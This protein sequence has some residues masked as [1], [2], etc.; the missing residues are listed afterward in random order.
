MVNPPSSNLMPD[1]TARLKQQVAELQESDFGLQQTASIAHWIGYGLLIFTLF[2]W[3]YLLIPLKVM[4]PRWEF[5]TMGGLVEQ[6]VVPLLGFGLVFFGADLSRK[7]WEFAL[8]KGLSWLCLLLGLLY[9][10]LLPLGVVN[11]VRLDGINQR[12]LV[13]NQDQRLEVIS[14]VKGQVEAIT[15]EADLQRVIEQLKK[16]GLSIQPKPG[17]SVTAIKADLTEFMNSAQAKL[18]TEV[19]AATKQGRFSLFK[20][21]LRW[22]LGAL[23]AGIWFIVLWRLSEWARLF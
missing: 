8:L 11:T 18:E 23:I 10:L 1:E 4:N 9:L 2:E 13:S 16:G 3:A 15:T 12:N 21:S 20:N 5:Q 7:C 22:N 14:Q 19:N 17:Q 6:V